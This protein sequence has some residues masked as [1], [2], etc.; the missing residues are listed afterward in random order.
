MGPVLRGSLALAPQ[1]GAGLMGP[2]LRGSLALA[3]QT[4]PFGI[5]TTFRLSVDML[6]C[7]A[8]STS[9]RAYSWLTMSSS[10]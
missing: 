6:M 10:G 9:A 4:G 1:T 5:M 7:I 8:A 3:P 2:V